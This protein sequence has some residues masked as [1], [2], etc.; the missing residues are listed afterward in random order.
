MS[1]YTMSLSQAM[2]LLFGLGCVAFGAYGVAH[3][4]QHFELAWFIPDGSHMKRFLEDLNLHY[5]HF[6]RRGSVYWG[7]MNYSAEMDN[8]ALLDKQLRADKRVIQVDSWA[9]AY[10]EWLT[11]HN[12]AEG[13]YLA[14]CCNSRSLATLAFLGKG[15]FLLLSRHFPL[16][17]TDPVGVN[18]LDRFSQFLFSPNGAP[19]QKNFKFNGSL[20]CGQPLPPI[21]VS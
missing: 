5:P 7:A 9:V 10:E 18:F 4:R 21:M 8:V 3:I 15:I 2:V 12:I 17:F 14:I 16:P 11:K 6:G 1:L 19:Y 13:E 20:A